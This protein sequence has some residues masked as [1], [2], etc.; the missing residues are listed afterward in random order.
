MFC[1]KL[2]VCSIY[3]CVVFIFFFFFK[4]KT[5]YEMRIS[6]W[7]SDVCSSDLAFSETG[8]SQSGIRD[9]A[10]IA[11]VSSTLLLRYYGSKTALLEAALI[12]AMPIGDLLAT[13][14]RSQFGEVLARAF[15]DTRLDKI[16]RAHV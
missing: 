14:E 6:D 4:Q 2:R 8:Y 1:Y 10:A 12:E 13:T 3:G 7:S 15:L 9:I 5:A 16:G 11:D